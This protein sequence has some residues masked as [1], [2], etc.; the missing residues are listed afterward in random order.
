VPNR[1]KRLVALDQV[2]E[3]SKYNT[4]VQLLC[5][6]IPVYLSIDKLKCKSILG[7]CFPFHSKDLDELGNAAC[8]VVVGCFCFRKPFVQIRPV[9]HRGHL[10]WIKVQHMVHLHRSNQGKAATPFSDSFDGWQCSRQA[11]RRLVMIS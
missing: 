4:A 7:I 11:I 9:E 8:L 1:Q 5:L 2:A 10:Y 3:E 6:Q